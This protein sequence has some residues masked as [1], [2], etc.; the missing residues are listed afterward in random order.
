MR[1]ATL[2]WLVIAAVFSQTAW[3]LA[4]PEAA[5]AEKSS[6]AEKLI[7]SCAPKHVD[8]GEEIVCH[9]R[10]KQAGKISGV[11]VAIDDA[12][13]VSFETR[14]YSWVTNKSAFYFV[15]QRSSVRSDQILRMTEFLDRAAYPTG[16]R[17]I[18]LATAGKSLIEEAVIGS[19]RRKLDSETRKLRGEAPGIDPSAILGSLDEA[20]TAV[21]R[22]TAERRA[23]VLLTDADPTTTGY[24]EGRIVDRAR[25]LNIPIYVVSFGESGS[26]PSD[27]LERL[28]D[29]TDGGTFDV[30]GYDEKK[31]QAFA[32]AFPEYLDNGEVVTIPARGLAEKSRIVLSAAVEGEKGRLESQ[33]LDVKRLTEDPFH[34]KAQI[35]LMNNLFAVLAIWGLVLGGVLVLVSGFGS[36]GAGRGGEL[37]ASGAPAF[38]GSDGGAGPDEATR[39]FIPDRRNG[40]SGAAKGW[41]ELVGSDESPVALNVG[42]FRIGRS[43][44]NDI[45]LTNPSVHRSHAL[46]QLDGFGAATIHDMGTRNG[47]YVNGNRCEKSPLADGD[48]IELGEVKLRYT[49]APA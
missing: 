33:G 32:L 24:N 3:L 9:L 38:G 4:A 1:P 41:L 35:F 20:I 11:E 12:S 15:V 25:R 42:H 5:A 30:S 29:K 14:P 18:G 6:A 26:P 7:A 19:T 48:V 39:I 10:S 23:V 28:G 45:R 13:G 36:G 31:L 27:V 47:V 17:V 22:E 8:D 2:A 21:A 43:A 44:D 16:R 37:V 40:D 46:L 49:S 34:V